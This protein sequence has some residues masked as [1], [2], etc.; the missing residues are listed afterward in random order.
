MTVKQRAIT[1]T[2]ISK[3]RDG[4][5]H[6]VANQQKALGKYAAS[7]GWP[8]GQVHRGEADCDES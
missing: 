6:G 2:R 3:D 5:R 4:D 7:R 1:Q 8:A